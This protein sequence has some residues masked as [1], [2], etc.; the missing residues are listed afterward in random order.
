MLTQCEHLRSLCY[1]DCAMLT[2]L[3]GMYKV[4][5]SDVDVVLDFTES[6]QGLHSHLIP[7]PRRYKAEAKVRE[8]ETVREV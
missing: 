2:V 1:V 4:L 6:C 7:P 5:N 8:K 3:E